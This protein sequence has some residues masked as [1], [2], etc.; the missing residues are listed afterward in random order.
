LLELL[1]LAHIEFLIINL[2][3]SFMYGERQLFSPILIVD[4]EGTLLK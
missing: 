1:G 2:I 4:V 3:G